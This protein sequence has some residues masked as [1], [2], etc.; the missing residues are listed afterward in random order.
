MKTFLALLKLSIVNYFGLTSMR[1]KYVRNRQKLWEPIV[2]AF[3]AITLIVSLSTGAFFLARGLIMS[4]PPGQADMGLTLPILLTQV[5]ALFMGLFALISIFYFSNDLETL[6]PLPLKEKAILGSKFSI[7]NITEYLPALFIVI[8]AMIAY[9][10]YIPLG[11]AGWASAVVVFLLLPIVPLSIAGI[12]VVTLMR[13]LNRRH[14]D[15]MIVLSSLILLAV[16]MYVQFLFQSAV[17]NDVDIEAILQNRVDLVRLIGSAFP[18]SVW[19]TRAISRAGQTEGFVGLAYLVFSSALG[20]WAFLSVGQR[21]FY[22]GLIGGAEHERKN[23]AFTQQVLSKRATSTPVLK[24]LFLREWRLFLR[25][26]IWV[27]NGFISVILI[28]LMAFFPA[29][30]GGQGLQELAN[31]AKNAPNGLVASTLVFAGMIAALTS[32]NTL[33]STSISREG[34]H[35]WISR[36]LPVQPRLQVIAKL[37]HAGLA[38]LII[39]IPISGLF[40]YLFRPQLMYVLSAGILGLT[41]SAMPQLL[42]MLFDI[43]HPFLTWTNPQHAVKNNLNAVTPLILMVPSGVITY[44]SFRALSS[45][46]EGAGILLVLT[47]AHLAIAAISFVILLRKADIWYEQ[48]E[49]TG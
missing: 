9:N 13:G 25:V 43:W 38:S 39:A 1:I 34:K 18:P 46:L 15:I 28:P 45:A 30:T 42:G 44:F 8:P 17:M 3:A 33:A 36:I 22:G 49:I 4:A 24:A 31:W 12:I 14:R 20:V 23:I 2:I 35:L 40:Y 47:A 5:L 29:F 7:A 11:V 37:M 6:V 48:L 27:L 32:I 21:V 16:I 19:A 41:V 26:P 10:Q